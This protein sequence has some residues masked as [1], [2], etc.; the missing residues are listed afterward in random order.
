MKIGMAMIGA[1]ALLVLGTGAGAGL[2]A[3][4]Q[5]RV[6]AAAVQALQLSQ[7]LALSAFAVTDQQ[8]ARFGLEQ[9]RGRWSLLFFGYTHCPDVCTPTLR[10]L[11]RVRAAVGAARHSLQVVFVSVDNDRDSASRLT[12]YL[13]GLAEPGLIGLGGPAEAVAALTSQLGVYH[14]R[15]AD[16]G[17]GAYLV[18][19]TTSVFLVAPDASLLA[20]F[21]APHRAEKLLERV[22]LLRRHWERRHA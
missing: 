18:D 11:A 12:E 16:N 3:W 15:G 13:A 4:Q 2:H 5:H 7:P 10:E 21:T 1:A 19:H 22:Q 17:H 9:L 20:V 8:G 14:H 6:E